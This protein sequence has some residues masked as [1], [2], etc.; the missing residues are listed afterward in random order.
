MRVFSDIIT[1][2]IKILKKHPRISKKV[3]ILYDGNIIFEK[4][5]FTAIK[6]G[7]QIKPRI[8]N[9]NASKLMKIVGLWM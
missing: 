4:N 8:L 3:N 9:F 7:K 5:A 1:T 2:K 6:D